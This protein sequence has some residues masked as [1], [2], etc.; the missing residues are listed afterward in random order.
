M[1][2]CFFKT[3]ESNIVQFEEKTYFAS[4][5]AKFVLHFG[6]FIILLE[7]GV[8]CWKDRVPEDQPKTITAEAA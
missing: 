2:R 4:K 5:N 8:E 3:L 6:S 7:H 1:G